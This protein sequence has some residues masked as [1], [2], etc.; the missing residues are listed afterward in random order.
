MSGCIL[1]AVDGGS[2]ISAITAA[3]ELARRD[4]ARLRAIGLCGDVPVGMVRASAP[5]AASL[6]RRAEI[7]AALDAA[8]TRAREL[9]IPFDA[10]MRGGSPERALLEEAV[11]CRADRVVVEAA[12]PRGPRWRRP[13]AL[14]RAGRDAAC[15]IVATGP[16]ADDGRSPVHAS[17]A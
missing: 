16:A 7:A 8:S 3:L 15:R 6:H 10:A 12:G 17:A 14:Q 1:V 11:R 9:D 2:S 13:R 4:D 5:D